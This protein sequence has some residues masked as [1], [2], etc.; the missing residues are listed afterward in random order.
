MAVLSAEGHRPIDLA[1]VDDDRMLLDGLA[2]W[3]AE[4]PDLRLVTAVGTVEELLATGIPRASVVLLDMRL[5]DH[6]DP[7]EN[8]RRLTA[9]SYQVL[10]VS[11]FDLR[12]YVVGHFALEPRAT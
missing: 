11:V 9:A 5:R 7:V 4:A 2:R 12:N 8:V 1:V 10:V 3:L 6:S